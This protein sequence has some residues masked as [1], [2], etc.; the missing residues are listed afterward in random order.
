MDALQKRAVDAEEAGDLSLAL[1]LW[2]ER[3]QRADEDGISFLKY[4]RV[5][6]KLEKWDESEDALTQALRLLPDFYLIKVFMGTLWL[7]RTDKDRTTSLQT[8]KEWFLT[9][10]KT[11]RTAPTFTFLGTAY[12]ELDEGA[13]A[14]EAF[15]EAI[16]LDPNYEEAIYNLAVIE[17]KTNPQKARELLEKAIQID[18]NYT[19]AHQMLGR[20][21]QRMKDRISAEFHFRRCLEIDPADYWSSLYLANLLAVLKRN[22]EAEQ[23]FRTATELRPEMAGGFEFF[24]RFLEK[25]GKT[26]EAEEERAKIKPSERAAAALL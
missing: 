15:E 22:S 16:K 14:K 9:A 13:A 5:A 21:C 17:E 12:A 26:A 8:A 25:I 23:A 7:H 2:K 1:E 3:S 19:L 18:P 11:K 10:L 4:G 6:Q 24:A 20:V